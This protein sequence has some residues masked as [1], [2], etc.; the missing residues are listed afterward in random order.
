MPQRTGVTQLQSSRQQAA[1][2]RSP[3]LSPR[4]RPAAAVLAASCALVTALIGVQV[5]HQARPGWLDA[6]VD[7]RIQAALGV[8]SAVLSALVNLGD[9]KSVTVLAL[10]TFLACLGTRRYRGAWLVAVAL[11]AAGLAEVLLKPL[12]GR[13]RFGGLS[14][15]SGHTIG[16]FALAVTIVVLLIGPLRPPLRP[17][18]RVLLAGA[19]LVIACAV[20][21]SLIALGMHYFT[22]TVGGAAVS[23]ALVLT[24]ALI[25]DGFADRGRRAAHARAAGRL[26]SGEGRPPAHRPPPTSA[27]AAAHQR[28]GRRPPAH[29]PPP[30][31]PLTTADVYPADW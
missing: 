19:A 12:V 10:G 6:A 31:G 14:Y 24:T 9:L 29:R 8:H 30:T 23:I 4:F 17:M 25:V 11:P 7:S 27:S 5:A 21:T 18:P 15:P 1:P 20:A 2:L 3:L 16:V 26:A 22:D 13:T 28:I